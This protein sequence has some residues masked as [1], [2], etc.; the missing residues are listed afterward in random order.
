MPEKDVFKFL[1]F[2][3]S[4]TK[5]ILNKHYNLD[6]GEIASSEKITVKVTSRY[7]EIIRGVDLVFVI[8]LKTNPFLGGALKTEPVTKENRKVIRE[9]I[10]KDAKEE[11]SI[12]K[13][14]VNVKYCNIGNY[15]GERYNLPNYI[16][17][18]DKNYI[19]KLVVLYL[20]NEDSESD[21]LSEEDK[22]EL[23]T[24][25]ERFSRLL[26]LQL[27]PQ[28]A[29]ASILAA[30]NIKKVKDGKRR[31][32][33]LDIF[34]SVMK[35]T[36]QS[37]DFFFEALENRA[38]NNGESLNDYIS[39]FNYSTS[40]LPE[41]KFCNTFDPGALE[42]IYFSLLNLSESLEDGEMREYVDIKES[43]FV[44]ALGSFLELLDY[45]KD[46]L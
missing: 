6:N 35:E 5:G 3:L 32:Y 22:A 24:L 41:N 29:S 27:C 4:D 15:Q 31:E 14:L 18:I 10:L 8:N 17:A 13:M 9:L 42:V 11:T 12:D 38:K 40:R 21:E 16:L 34:R 19:E 30:K 37:S 45:G 1:I 33:E 25:E 28:A 2:K 46:R 36:L 20:K 23:I 7:D 44:A 26:L 39:G 43:N